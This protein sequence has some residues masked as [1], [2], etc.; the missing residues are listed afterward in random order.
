MI[1]EKCG[2]LAFYGKNTNKILIKNFIKRLEK[3]QHRG[4]DSVGICYLDDNKEYQTFY[5]KETI[6]DIYF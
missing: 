5:E 1:S 2:L 4:R 3:I 6:H